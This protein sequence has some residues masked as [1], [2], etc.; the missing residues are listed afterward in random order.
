MRPL[1]NAVTRHTIL[2]V[3]FV[4]ALAASVAAAPQ[5]G[6]GGHSG[7]GHSGGQSGG[8]H[9]MGGQPHVDGPRG[10]FN[11]P[12]GRIIVGSRFYD[13]FWGPFYPYG[14]GWGYPYSYPYGPY[15][16]SSEITGDVKTD[17]TP[18]QAEVY[19]DGYY[20][21]VADDFDGAFQRLH[22]SPG[23]HA[24]TLHLDGYRTIT[25]SVY[26][27]PDGTYKLKVTMEKLAPGEVAAPVPQIERPQG[28]TPT[29]GGDSAPR[30]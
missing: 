21:G 1:I 30:R 9:S 10:H 4:F 16:Y 7:G 6:G 3:T 11:G 24:V 8:S 2:T 19:V 15:D 12:R 27:Q 22:T 25:R 28:K 26:V 17:V 20:A 29:P 13:P 14:Y 23:G 18:K 5:R